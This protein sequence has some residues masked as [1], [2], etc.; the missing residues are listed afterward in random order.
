MIAVDTNLLI[1]AHRKASPWFDVASSALQN[2]A[3]SSA[4]WAIPWPCLHEFLGVATHPRVFAPPSSLREAIRQVEAWMESPSL[5]L[6]G[7]SPGHWKELCALAVAGTIQGPQI[8]D[9]RIAAI[10][11]EHGVREFWTAD[12]DFS[13][14]PSLKVRNPL[15]CP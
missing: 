3:E 10:C 9:A 13:R 6:I 1:H 2:L 12:R 11:I 7:E 8:H 14:F 4:R 15:I 5:Q